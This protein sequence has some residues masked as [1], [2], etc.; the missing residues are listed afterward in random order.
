M[1]REQFQE[2]KELPTVEESVTGVAAR[3][4]TSDISAMKQKPVE[5]K[6]GSSKTKSPE[7]VLE[8]QVVTQRRGGMALEID[9]FGNKNKTPKKTID[10]KTSTSNDILI[11]DSKGSD[12]T[13][14]I[15]CN[16]TNST[17][18]DGINVGSTP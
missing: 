4:R 9:W 13:T 8:S 10:K 17:K 7:V 3:D 18:P 15:N 16:S 1:I 6:E 11:N 5:A 2:V 12:C 14:S